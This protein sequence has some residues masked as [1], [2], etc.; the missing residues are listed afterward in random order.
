VTAAVLRRDSGAADLLV[1]L[2]GAYMRGSDMVRA[3][4]LADLEQRRPQLDVAIVD[5]DLGA[6]SAGTALPRVEAEVLAPARRQGRRRIWLG[7]IS[8]GGLLALGHAADRPGAIDGLCLISP[9]PGS[10]LTLGAIAGAGGL[11]R[12]Q[13]TAGQLAD[14]EF[15]AWRWLKRPPPALPVFVG[16]GRGDRFADGMERVAACFAPAQRCVVPGGHDWPTWR[17]LWRRFLESPQFGD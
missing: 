3:G 8:L 9:Y 1:L 10:R 12:W 17:E 7:G 5:L 14:P 15:R 2:P 16:Y 11:Q 13:P 6:V 4:L